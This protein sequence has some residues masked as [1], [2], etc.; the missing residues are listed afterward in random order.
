MAGILKDSFF[1][2][3]QGDESFC[4]SGE[5]L[6]EHRGCC[7]AAP[8][9]GIRHQATKVLISCAAGDQDGK[10]AFVFHGELC[11]DKGANSLFVCGRV[12][13]G[14][15]IKSVAITHRDGRKTQPCR[16]A[17]QVF[18]IGGAP[19]KAEGAAGMEL[20]V[21]HEE[22][23]RL[24]CSCFGLSPQKLAPRDGESAS[25]GSVRSQTPCLRFIAAF[26]F[27]DGVM[28]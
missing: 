8:Q 20:K 9:S 26:D 27:P 5:F 14:R 3:G 1:V 15:A 10:N 18:R 21:D 28:A 13:A 17:G 24:A 16:G 11:T 12:Q 6:P 23:T 25:A 7:F 2:A 4:I 19:Q 22:H